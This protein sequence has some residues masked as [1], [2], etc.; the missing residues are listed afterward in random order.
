MSFSR[1][2]GQ[3][4][5]VQHSGSVQLQHADSVRPR[6]GFVRRSAGGVVR[7]GP[8][9]HQQTATASGKRTHK[10]HFKGSIF[11]FKAIIINFNMGRIE[12]ISR[13]KQF[14]NTAS[15]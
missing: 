1:C 12:R 4:G 3:H 13:K 7:P 2:V 15:D 9:R 10:A 14:H 11:P 6:K 8:K 5:E